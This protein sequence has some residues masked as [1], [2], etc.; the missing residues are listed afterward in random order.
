MGVNAELYCSVC[1]SNRVG[2]F[3]RVASGVQWTLVI[4]YLLVWRGV[5]LT[6]AARARVPII[7]LR[8]G[9]LLYFA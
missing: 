6:V 1:L 2:L 8:Y 4:D 5:I 7:G 3:S 9:L